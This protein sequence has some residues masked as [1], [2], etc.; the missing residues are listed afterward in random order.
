VDCNET[1]QALA[2]YLDED[3]RAELCR[4]IEEHL[5][6]CRD[7]RVYV[8]TIKKTIVLYQAGEKIEMPVRVNA[9]LT[10]ALAREYAR[11][12]QGEPATSD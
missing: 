9:R 2:D 5:H 12:A 7:C 4:T 11:T 6:R 8:D 10:E 1:L 3:A